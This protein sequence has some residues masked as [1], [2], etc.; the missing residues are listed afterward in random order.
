MAPRPQGG[1]AMTLVAISASY[2][3]GGSRIGPA[4][5]ERLRVPFIDRAIPMSQAAEFEPPSENEEG[6]G[7]LERLLR[8]FVGAESSVTG[9]VATI[10]TGAADDF[11]RE[12]EELLRR[13]A[14]T[15]GGVIL[16]RAAVAVLRDDP[17]VLRVRL[18]G[19]PEA[20]IEQAVGRFGVDREA[21]ARAVGKLDRTHD[22][23][24]KTFYGLDIRDPALYHIVLD[25]TALPFEAC[26][27]I[28][29]RAARAMRAAPVAAV[30]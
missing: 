27:E 29:V 15:G 17:R 6:V 19:S 5:A 23:Y 22:A 26:A 25:S 30:R 16:G 28:V 24:L 12:S 10:G 7:W 3:A 11:R 2:G 20:R 18:D 13:Q 4:V 1:P 8:G 14:E 21:A 9:P